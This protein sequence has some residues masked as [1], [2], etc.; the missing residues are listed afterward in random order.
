MNQSHFRSRIHLPV[1]L[2]LDNQTTGTSPNVLDNFDSS[3]VIVII[4]IILISLHVFLAYPIPLNPVALYLEDYFGRYSLSLS[5]SH[6]QLSFFPRFL[7]I[8]VTKTKRN[9]RAN[10][11]TEKGTQVQN[12][13]EN[14]PRGLHINIGIGE[15]V[16]PSFFCV[17][18]VR[19]FLSPISA[20]IM[21]RLFPILPI[22]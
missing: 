12:R 8:A 15:F 22:C 18:C 10:P 3:Q 6:W 5:L 16:G 14:A 17:F 2:S 7:M 21:G 1:S 13:T 19:S 4:A 20:L 11:G 9:P